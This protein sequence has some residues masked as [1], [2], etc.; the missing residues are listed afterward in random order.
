[1]VPFNSHNEAISL[2]MDSLSSCISRM[3]S[4]LYSDP[5]LDTLAHIKLHE[6]ADVS[7]NYSVILGTVQALHTKAKQKLVSWS[8]S[9]TSFAAVADAMRTGASCVSRMQ[10]VDANVVNTFS[11]VGLNLDDFVQRYITECKVSDTMSRA[12]MLANIQNVKSSIYRHKVDFT[13]RTKLSSSTTNTL[14]A[15]VLPPAEIV[16]EYLAYI[17]TAITTVLQGDSMPAVYESYTADTQTTDKTS[18]FATTTSSNTE[19][20][21]DFIK[22]HDSDINSM[23]QQAFAKFMQDIKVSYDQLIHTHLADEFK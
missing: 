14:F 9:N 16:F 22:A 23:N 18:V 13:D 6:S 11:S 1:M 20:L 19:V 8:Q 21:L 12:E 7:K 17:L 10:E 15:C 3:S 5:I 2:I 4:E